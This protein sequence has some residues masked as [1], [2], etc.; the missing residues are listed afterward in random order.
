MLASSIFTQTKNAANKFDSIFN[1]RCR[2][3]Y[4]ILTNSKSMIKGV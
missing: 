3:A 1:Y 2:V 4:W